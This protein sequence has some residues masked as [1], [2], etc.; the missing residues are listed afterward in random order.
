MPNIL[1]AAHGD[2]STALIR[3]ARLIVGATDGI[4]SFEMTAGLHH[5][6]AEQQL[7][8][9][10]VTGRAQQERLLVLVDIQGGSPFN[11]CSRLLIAHGDFALV[12]GL[13]FPMVLESLTSLTP[14]TGTHVV[15]AGKDSVI[16][17]SALIQN[18]ENNDD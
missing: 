6:D 9:L 1:I 14:S 11:I 17:I 13:N 3:S 5:A 16:D 15:T 18:T 2:P 12:A 7:T 8:E 10:V 4:R